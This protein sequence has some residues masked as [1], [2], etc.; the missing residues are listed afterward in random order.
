MAKGNFVDAQIQQINTLVSHIAVSTQD[1]NLT[2]ERYIKECRIPLNMTLI[3][4]LLGAE[5]KEPKKAGKECKISFRHLLPSTKQLG[6]IIEI[7]NKFISDVEN[8]FLESLY[9]TDAS[10]D[11]DDM[12]I[13][14][15][16]AVGTA[17]ADAIP[18]KEKWNKKELKNYIFGYNGVPSIAAYKIGSLD[19]MRI[20]AAGEEAKKRDI[21][22]KVLIGTGITVAITAGVVTGVYIYNK[23]KDEKEMAEIDV[24]V[25]VVDVDDEPDLIGDDDIPQVD[26]V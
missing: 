26:L 2:E 10:S 16:A 1:P 7:V 4:T 20:A 25:N 8:P 18:N 9:A 13:P 24:E 17:S 23:K 15:R 21:T 22:K 3:Q 14:T 11:D 12:A 19:C 6:D 5:I